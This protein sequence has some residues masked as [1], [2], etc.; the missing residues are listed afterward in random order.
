MNVILFTCFIYLKRQF[1]HL[2]LFFLFWKASSKVFEKHKKT[3]MAH[4]L[5]RSCLKD[6]KRCENHILQ[7]TSRLYMASADFL[8]MQLLHDFLYLM[9][10]VIFDTM[11]T[12]LM[13]IFS[14]FSDLQK[15]CI[16]SVK[17]CCNIFKHCFRTRVFNIFVKY[18]VLNS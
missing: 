16:F 15:W 5:K 14:S 18:F 11:T 2:Q 3:E 12:R 17:Q 6:W 1:I 8:Q 7:Q 9:T 13:K 4:R 10:T